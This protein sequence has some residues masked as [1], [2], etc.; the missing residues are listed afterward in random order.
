M[1]NKIKK[2]I[3]MSSNRLNIAK[4]SSGTIIGFGISII[5]LPI[6]TRLYGAEIIGVWALLLSI[7]VIINS[8]SDLGLTQSLMLESDDDVEKNYKVVSTLSAGISIILS[9]VIT[10]LY[11]LFFEELKINPIF[12]FIL[13]TILAF[14][15]QQIQICYTWLNRNANYNVLMKNPVINNGVYGILAIILGLF[16]YVTYGY[17]IAQIIG[18]FVTLFHMRRNLPKDMFSLQINNFIYV[19]KKNKRFL[20]Y[21]VPSNIIGKVKSELT[22]LLINTFWGT[23]MVGYYSIALKLLHMPSS[24][25]ASAI[26][27]VFFQTTSAMKRQEKEIGSFVYYT[28]SQA[29]KMGILP[30]AFLIAFGDIAVSIFLGEEWVIAGKF[31]R[32]L[33]LQYFFIFIMNTVQGLSI[34]LDKQEYAILS[35]TAQ[36]IAIVFSMSIGLLVFNDIYISLI[37]MSSL[38][39]LINIIY[40]CALYKVMKISRWEFLKNV[41]ITVLLMIGLGTFLRNGFAFLF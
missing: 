11:I 12:F 29:M 21:Q 36:M 24:L 2:S 17:F 39:I 16:G 41:T 31:L 3:K 4:I 19:M 1:L 5:T 32:I 14:T 9:G 25:L 8:L 40:Y 23:E 27:R 30:I 38:I 28:M 18:Q 7:S 10:L 35:L 34:T 6:I 13:L 15:K 37:I 20:I 33:A 22:T 26:G